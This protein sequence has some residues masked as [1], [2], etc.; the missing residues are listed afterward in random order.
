MDGDGGNGDRPY[1]EQLEAIRMIFRRD[2]KNHIIDTGQITMN[3]SS[4]T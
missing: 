2:T 4:L 1:G 3:V